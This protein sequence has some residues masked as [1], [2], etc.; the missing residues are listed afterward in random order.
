MRASFH[1]S[2]G[3]PGA[4]LARTRRCLLV[5]GSRLDASMITTYLD[6]STHQKKSYQQGF[7]ITMK[8]LMQLF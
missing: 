5:K 1:M 6:L 4:H 2:H 3:T 7:E 8:F